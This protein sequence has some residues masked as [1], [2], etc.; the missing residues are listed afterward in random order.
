MTSVRFQSYTAENQA[1]FEDKLIACYQAVFAGWPWFEAWPY[2]QVKQ[3]LRHE[4]TPQASCWLALSDENVI[5]FCWGYPI[6]RTELE[7]KLGVPL[8]DWSGCE[9]IPELIA[10]QDE[11]GVLENCRGQKIARKLFALRLADFEAQGLEF[12]VVRTKVLPEPSVTY[13]WF[14]AKLGY[15]EMARYSQGDGRVVLGAPLSHVRSLF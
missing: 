5:G 11:L 4:I 10:Y 6:G 13:E 7:V 1:Q 14:T 3:D 15:R 9:R 12:G 2:E 8:E